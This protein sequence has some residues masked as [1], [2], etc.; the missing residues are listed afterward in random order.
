MSLCGGAFLSTSASLQFQ[1]LVILDHI[2]KKLERIESIN[3]TVARLF[4]HIIASMYSSYGGTSRRL[5]RRMLAAGRSFASYGLQDY[6][7]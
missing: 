2:V 4:G 1:T 5:S 7:R 3:V 6:K